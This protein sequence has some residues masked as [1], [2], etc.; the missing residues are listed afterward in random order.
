MESPILFR[1]A[2]EVEDSARRQE[3]EAF[4]GVPL[5]EDEL[6]CA[7]EALRFLHE[8]DMEDLVLEPAPFF[9]IERAV[10]IGQHT[11]LG[12]AHMTAEGSA[13]HFPR[14]SI[15]PLIE[16]CKAMAQTGIMLVG[17][18]ARSHE[19]WSNDPKI[20]YWPSQ[21]CPAKTVQKRAKPTTGSY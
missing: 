3:V 16:L 18:Q 9:F 15:V 6:L 1:S 2:G 8:I 21:H 10:A 14:K 11:V 19:A 17:A 13:G 7:G 4:L 20:L 12:L 5:P